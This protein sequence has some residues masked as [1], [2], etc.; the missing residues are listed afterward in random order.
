MEVFS[1]VLIF[2]TLLSAHSETEQPI[3]GKYA[4]T[5]QF[6]VFSANSALPEFAENT[7]FAEFVVCGKRTNILK[8]QNIKKWGRKKLPP[9]SQSMV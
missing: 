6:P 8:I 9:T 5:L 7:E 2:G 3:L 4:K 1:L